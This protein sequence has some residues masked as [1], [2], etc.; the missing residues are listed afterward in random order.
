MNYNVDS[1]CKLDTKN[2][3]TYQIYKEYGTGVMEDPYYEIE[4]GTA[5]TVVVCS[6]FEAWITCAW[7]NLELHGPMSKR[8]SWESPNYRYRKLKQV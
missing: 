7:K 8:S 5:K 1:I 3:F 6:E 2:V 4:N